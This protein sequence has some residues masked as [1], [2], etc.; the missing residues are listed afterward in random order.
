MGNATASKEEDS[1]FQHGT[2]DCVFCA[3]WH[4]ENRAPFELVLKTTKFVA[5]ALTSDLCK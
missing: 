1:F 5:K 2:G 3:D 4:A